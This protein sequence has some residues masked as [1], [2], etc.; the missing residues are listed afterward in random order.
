MRKQLW[1]VETTLYDRHGW[2][3]RQPECGYVLVEAT[4]ERE[5]GKKAEWLSIKKYKKAVSA[6][7]GIAEIVGPP[8]VEALEE[9][10]GDELIF[11]ESLKTER[12]L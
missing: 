3:L 9:I 7:W 6:E 11:E 5:A 2:M 1:Y 12:P 4:N 10:L 8:E